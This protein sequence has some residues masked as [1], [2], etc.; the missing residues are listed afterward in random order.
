ML[1]KGAEISYPHTRRMSV[2]V[3]RRERR[4]RRAK[5]AREERGLGKVE[6]ESLSE[7]L[8]RLF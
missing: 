4:D 6:Q 2:N 5:K 3:H 1:A 7:T 8:Q